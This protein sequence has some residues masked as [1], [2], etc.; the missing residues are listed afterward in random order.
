MKLTS[1]SRTDWVAARSGP[2]EA[3]SY[4]D[5]RGRPGFKLAL[6]QAGSR[7]FL[8]VAHLWHSG[9]SVLDVTDPLAPKQVGS[10]SGP[11]NTWT[12]QVTIRDGLM[13]TSMERIQSGWGGNGEEP[14]DEGVILWDLSDPVAPSRRGTFRTSHHGTHRNLFDSSG[15]LHLSAR[16]TGYN[17]AIHVMV[18]VSD[19]DAPREVGRFHMHGQHASN[20]ERSSRDWLDLHGPAV[21][22]GNLAYLP[23]SSAGLVILDIASP[24]KPVM[25]GNLEVHP[26][27]G[28]GIAVHT[29]LPVPGRQGMVIINSEAL[30]E[31]CDESVGYAAVVDV[32]DPRKPKIISL[33]PTPVPPPGAD[34][35]SFCERGGRFGPHNQ[36]MTTGDPVLFDGHGVCFL[37]YFNA[38]LRVYDVRDP[39]L[40][41]EVAYLIPNDP[42][43]RYGPLP[44]DLVVQVEDVLVDSRG[45]VY[46]TEKNS[47]LYIAEWKGL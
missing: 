1:K 43:K 25:V 44:T 22:Q 17:G 4:H 46:F 12:L 9:W 33:F 37:T 40:V 11:P 6:H 7:L 31:R 47:G 10:W 42:P 39:Y 13:A 34:Y 45:I 8:Y 35:S 23:Y 19:P 20:G 15:L 5:L 2:I 16:M 14:F 18:D 28:S 32:S 30:A 24:D 3:L 26:P 21:R 27:L 38:G 36:H 41:R 29:V